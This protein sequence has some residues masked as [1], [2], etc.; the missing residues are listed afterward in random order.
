[1]CH[2]GYGGS[3]CS[4]CAPGFGRN[5]SSTRP[6]ECYALPLLQARKVSVV[7]VVVVVGV[8]VLLLLL[9][10]RARRHC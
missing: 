8:V 10:M 9:C 2:K 6:E 5:G 3:D 7:C 4:S 1:V